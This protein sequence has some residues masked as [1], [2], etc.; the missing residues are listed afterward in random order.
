MEYLSVISGLRFGF[1]SDYKFYGSMGRVYNV[2]VVIFDVC[3][4][5]RVVSVVAL[6]GSVL[7]EYDA[8]YSVCCEEVIFCDVWNSRQ[9]GDVMHMVSH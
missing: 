3:W 2:V 8:C 1:L 4:C 7:S 6:R 5:V 9:M